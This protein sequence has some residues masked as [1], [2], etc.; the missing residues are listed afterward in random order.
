MKK[1]IVDDGGIDP[2]LRESFIPALKKHIKEKDDDYLLLAIGDTGTG[3]STLFL[4]VLEKYLGEKSSE[5]LIGLDKQ[6]IADAFKRVSLMDHPRA[7]VCDEANFSKR[8]SMSKFN[9]DLIDLYMSVRGLNI[10]HLWCNPSLEMID[11]YFVEEK[12]K[13]IFFC[14]SKIKGRRPYYYIEKKQLLQ[15]IKKYKK[16]SLDILSKVKKKYAKWKGWY[17]DYNG[18]LKKRYLEKKNNRMVDK[19]S[20][21]HQIYGTSKWHTTTFVADKLNVKTSTINK[22]IRLLTRQKKLEEG[23]HYKKDKG[24]NYVHDDGFK[25]MQE[26]RE[27]AYRKKVTANSNILKKLHNKNVT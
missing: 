12:I 13:G 5:N 23:I 21:F 9:K 16:I 3:K 6:Q 7:W 11:K 15:I 2:I 20:K 4:H 1:A 25:I 27:R 14:P 24:R 17:C 8:D 26:H 22:Y 10:L 19:I 18:F